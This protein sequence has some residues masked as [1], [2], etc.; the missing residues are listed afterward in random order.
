[1]KAAVY[2]G[3]GAI[4]PASSTEGASYCVSDSVGFIL[5]PKISLAGY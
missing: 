5:E 3:G 2:H 1:M 4:C